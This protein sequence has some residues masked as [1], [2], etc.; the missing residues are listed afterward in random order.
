MKTGLLLVAFATAGV[1]GC[2]STTVHNPTL[3]S[4]GG[5][6][7][8]TLPDGAVGI[9][10]DGG[11]VGRLEDGGD[12]DAGPVSP[13]LPETNTTYPA[14]T[15]DMAS[16]VLNSGG[17]VLATP[18]VISIVWKSD[19]YTSSIE[20]FGNKLGTSSFWSNTVSEY[21]VGTLTNVVHEI[22]TAPPATLSDD[23]IDA[24]VIQE[25]GNG[26]WPAADANTI[27]MVYLPSTTKIVTTDPDSGMVVDGCSSFSGYHTETNSNDT[28]AHA[29]HLVYGVV[30]EICT[31]PT[32]PSALASATETAAHE[33]AE[34]AT[35]PLPDINPGLLYFDPQHFA[36]E[37]Y[38]EGQ[39]EIGD[40]CEFYPSSYYQEGSDLPYYV[41]R[42]WSNASAKA[43]HDPCIPRQTVPY[44]NVSNTAPD[45]VTVTDSDGVKHTTEGY[46]IPVGTTKAIGFTMYSD[47]EVPGGWFLTAAEGDGVDPVTPSHLTVHL[48]TTQGVNGTTGTV[49]VTANSVA[50]KATGQIITIVSKHGGYPGHYMPI[51]IGT[52]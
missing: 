2:S 30:A 39:D 40:A 3:D 50:G 18:K 9:L 23:N 48:D 19:Q 31:D 27:Y 22:T 33:I 44:Y 42:L 1:A 25:V 37:V 17:T 29:T 49:T 52:Y 46:R 28:S 36:W 32:Q 11:V 35:D 5:D 45:S 12:D 20:D 47:A 21:G 8:E 34:A 38:Q 10:S 4:D 51:M 43:G 6:T 14:V 16:L 41:Q 15:P 26:D 13:G 7:T 24:L